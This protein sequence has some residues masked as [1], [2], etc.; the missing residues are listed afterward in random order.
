M[1]VG[2][3]QPLVINLLN[4]KYKEASMESMHYNGKKYFDELL[5]S[6]EDVT[7][8]VINMVRLSRSSL[9]I[10]NGIQKK[11]VLSLKE[12]ALIKDRVKRLMTITGVGEITRLLP[13][14]LKQANQTNSAQ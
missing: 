11:L 1:A 5:G 10:F 4:Y 12:N 2:L 9:E 3:K 6:L 7:E 13:G 8:S 14:C